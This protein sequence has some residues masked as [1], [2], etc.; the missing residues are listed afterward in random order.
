MQAF[1]VV[2]ACVCVCVYIICQCSRTI[3][4]V[5]SRVMNPLGKFFFCSSLKCSYGVRNSNSFKVNYRAYVKLYMRRSH[6]VC[7]TVQGADR[8]FCRN[9]ARLASLMCLS[10]SLCGFS[11]HI[12]LPVRY[13]LVSCSLITYTLS[14]IHRIQGVQI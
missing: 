6:R 7:T 3:S 2:L 4:S 5:T 11:M 14:C 1:R 10:F 9:R 13:V 12:T 8:P